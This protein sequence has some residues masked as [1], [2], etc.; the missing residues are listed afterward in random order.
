[1]ELSVSSWRPAVSPVLSSG[2]TD[3]GTPIDFSRDLG[4]E[5]GWVQSV[6]ADWQA[7][8]RHHV[9]F[10]WLSHGYTQTATASRDLQFNGT[11]FPLGQP[12][13]STF[14]W[15]T[16]RIGYAYD[17][18][19]GPRGSLGLVVDL[20]QNDV[21]ARLTGGGADEERRTSLPLPMLGLAG[22]MHVGWRVDLAADATGFGV[23]DNATHTYGGR[24]IDVD[25]A[26]TIAIAPRVAARVGYRDLNVRHLAATDT[27]RV[28]MH[29][30][31]AGIVVRF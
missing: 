30:P 21:T 25:I 3:S 16:W 5:A 13:T 27:G 31:E 1:M 7:A 29:G 9:R 26:A 6:R 18:I 10:E 17:V 11:T 4:L 8:H 15:T 22:R 19:A 14:R 2:R 24:L 23:P 12:V 28:E 20:K